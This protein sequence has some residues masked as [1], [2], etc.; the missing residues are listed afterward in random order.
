MTSQNPSPQVMDR[1]ETYLHRIV[2]FQCIYVVSYS[3]AHFR[4]LIAAF[5]LARLAGTR[6]K[7]GLTNMYSATPND[8]ALFIT[9]NSKQ[10]ICFLKSF[11]AV[12]SVCRSRHIHQGIYLCFVSGVFGEESWDVPACARGSGSLHFWLPFAD[13]PSHHMALFNWIS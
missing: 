13:R 12:G 8:N 6:P 10:Q 3:F 7:R 11:N 1:W 2:C 9:T 4:P 5:P